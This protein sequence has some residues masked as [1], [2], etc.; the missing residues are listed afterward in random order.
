MVQLLP[1]ICRGCLAH[2]RTALAC[3][4]SILGFCSLGVLQL[5]IRA[6]GGSLLRSGHGLHAR[7][8]AIRDHFDV[9]D[10]ILLALR[11]GKGTIYDREFLHRLVSVTEMIRELDFVR[12]ES[13]LSLATES[14]ASTE[15]HSLDF[16]GLLDDLEGPEQVGRIRDYVKRLG[17]Y[18]GTLISKDERATAILFTLNDG[19]IDRPAALGEL[20]ERLRAFESPGISFTLAGVPVAES[21]LGE[22]LARDFVIHFP[23]GILIVCC[24]IQLS[25]RRWE[26]ACLSAV[27]IAAVNLFVFGCL[28]HTLGI[29]EITT[30]ALPV[31]M[32]FVAVVDDIHIFG[33]VVSSPYQ[34]AE[35]ALDDALTRLARPLALTSITTCI[36][37]SSFILSPI[38]AVRHLGVFASIGTVFGLSW[39]YTFTPIALSLIPS[40]VE[41]GP[42]AH[43]VLRILKSVE[44]LTSRPRIA[45]AI[46]GVVVVLIAGTHRLNVQDG[47]EQGF[48]RESPLGEGFA[49]I[50]TSFAGSHILY[51]RVRF[52]DLERPFGRPDVF[53][54]M[55]DFERFL[56]ALPGVGGV[57]GPHR[58]LSAVAVV[59]GQ[60]EAAKNPEGGD[61]ERLVVALDLALGKGRRLRI[62]DEGLDS[63]L[64]RVFLNRSDYRTVVSALEAIESYASER[65]SRLGSMQIEPG[66]GLV[67]SRA[68]IDGLVRSLVIATVMTPILSA[69]VLSWVYGSWKSG[70]LALWPTL[71]TVGS[72]LGAMGWLGIPLGVATSVYLAITLGVGVDFAVHLQDRL[73]AEAGESPGVQETDLLGEAVVVDTAAVVGCVLV[74]TL[75]PVPATARL[76]W[77][78]MISMGFSSFLSL[79]GAYARG[80]PSARGTGTD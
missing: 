59:R 46:A 20:R 77:M 12:S 61:V 38:P 35:K 3:L 2:R 22:Y 36:G 45:W 76:G 27:N 7:E 62:L 24:V 10:P 47:W 57:A 1:R 8:Q 40:A 41:P 56:G 54:S 43:Y 75:S 13:V 26:L 28:G 11:K 70:I 14:L 74:L 39:S 79:Y 53:E 80:M 16:P 49:E 66:G 15:A 18:D 51:V 48:D 78:V 9:R 68:M 29:V 72:V 34:N 67:S 17:I 44:R 32:T 6:D 69:L 42:S 4:V 25:F 55:A 21:L 60:P 23:L 65:A 31:F 73:A 50:N 63:A 30:S 37:F 33:K 58:Y 71:V 5:E 64:V 52:P 19:E